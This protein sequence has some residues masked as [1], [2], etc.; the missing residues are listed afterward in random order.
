MA[1]E[2]HT[3]LSFEID[4]SI[5]AAAQHLDQAPDVAADMKNDLA[6][7]R[8]SDKTY[9]LIAHSTEFPER[10]E[11]GTAEISD[12]A[13]PLV[14][15]RDWAVFL[16]EEVSRYRWMVFDDFAFA[17]VRLRAAGAGISI[18]EV[19]DVES[20]DAF[21]FLA[22]LRQNHPLAEPVPVKPPAFTAAVI[23]FR[24]DMKIP[25]EGTTVLHVPLSQD[26][27]RKVDAI[28][29]AKRMSPS[30]FIRRLLHQLFH[31]DDPDR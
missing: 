24:V 15:D 17:P 14:S 31:K 12:T 21:L 19:K 16:K 18:Q 3:E 7:Y 27:M 2:S 11:T 28:A 8:C 10:D 22:S 30:E 9:Y 23:P 13:W 25:Q 1:R 26:L 5:V 4:A 29:Q 6:L 20:K